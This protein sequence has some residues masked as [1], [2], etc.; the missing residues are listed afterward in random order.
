MSRPAIL[1]I[2]VLVLAAGAMPAR[3]DFAAGMAAYDRGDYQT[4]YK[5]WLPLAETRH[6][7]SQYQIGKLHYR[8]QGVPKNPAEAFRWFRAAADWGHGSSQFIVA[9]MM[10]ENEVPRESDKIIREYYLK[11]AEYGITNAQYNLGLAYVDGE[12]GLIKSPSR[13]FK[14]FERAALQGH[15]RAQV[16]T[17]RLARL[18]SSVKAWAWIRIIEERGHP[19]ARELREYTEPRV[20]EFRYQEAEALYQELRKTVIPKE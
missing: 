4:A 7:E 1:L 8:G 19:D 13:A 9:S 18:Y 20:T 17:A 5:E 10:Q 12:L 11:A 15:L 3:A 16:V 6:T 2:V 14:W